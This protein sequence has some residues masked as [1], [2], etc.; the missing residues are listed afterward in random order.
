LSTYH[1]QE[2]CGMIYKGAPHGLRMTHK[3]RGNEDLLAFLKM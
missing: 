1:A 2:E 3:D